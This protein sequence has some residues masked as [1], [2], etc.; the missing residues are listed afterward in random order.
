P[1]SL[2]VTSVRGIGLE[3]T[4][5]ASVELGDIG[6]MKAAFGLRLAADFFGAAFFGAA[7]FIGLRAAGFFAAGFFD[8]FLPFLAAIID[9]PI[10]F[11]MVSV[12]ALIS[13]E[14]RDS[15]RMRKQKSVVNR[16][17]SGEP[18]FPLGGDA[19]A[20][21]FA[22]VLR[23]GLESAHEADCSMVGHGARR[24]RQR[25]PGGAGTYRPA[26]RLARRAAHRLVRHGGHRRGR[27]RWIAGAGAADRGH[28]ERSRRRSG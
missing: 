23:A 2:L 6:F 15:E 4:T 26:G 13:H 12:I 16:F 19:P 18:I 5:A 25:F 1:Q 27:D 14:Q 17:H 22:L 9:P 24:A 21:P 11:P 7:F 28:R 20:T 8:A 3:P 10:W